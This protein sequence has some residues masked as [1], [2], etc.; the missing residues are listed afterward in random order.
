MPQI[1]CPACQVVSHKEVNF[2]PSCGSDL[3]EIIKK[4]KIKET[5]EMYAKEFKSISIFCGIYLSSVLLILFAGE[6]VLLSRT[7][8][9]TVAWFDAVFILFFLALSNINIKPSLVFDPDKT[10]SVSL[11]LLALIP[12]LLIN[13]GYHFSIIKVFG[14]EELE[15][16]S[17]LGLSFLGM[18][19]YIVIMPG[20]FEELAFRG[21]LQEKFGRILNR[22]ETYVIVSALFAIA[23]LNLFSAPYYFALSLFLCH[24]RTKTN[25]LL[26]CIIFHA[27]HNLVVVLVEYFEL[28]KI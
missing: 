17:S 13:Y 3:R 6:D 21:I 5:Q 28:I 26:P 22:S 25:S 9:Y 12:V 4:R 14:I 8:L 24:M 20:V 7:F 18:V 1:K 19:V 27:L 16:F 15:G 11:A 2:C 10:K 23:H